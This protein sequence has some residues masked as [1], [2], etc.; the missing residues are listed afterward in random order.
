MSI[1]NDTATL[2]VDINS[3]QA[4]RRLAELKG[5]ADELR[6]SISD[7]MASGKADKVKIDIK[8]FKDVQREIKQ[9]QA[10]TVTAQE[11]M[12]RLDKAAPME[13]R[14]TLKTLR[15]ELEFCERGTEAWAKKSEEIRKVKEEIASV[16]KEL[17]AQQKV[18]E[19]ATNWIG[20]LYS[21]ATAAF[22]GAMKAVSGME[23]MIQAYADMDTA[24]ADTQKFTG[25]TAEDVKRLN[26]EFKKMDTRTSREELNALAS[27]AGRL[28]KQTVEDVLGF[29]RAGDQIKVAM[30]ELGDDAPQIISQLAGVF[31]LESEMGTE[32]AMLSVGSAINTLSQNCAASAPNLV[33]F[34]SR[35]GAMAAATGMTMDEMLSFGSIL[36][37]NRVSVEKS[38]TAMQ[39]V[40]NKMLADPSKFAEKAGMDVEKFNEALKRSS[41]EGLMMFIERLSGMDK[42]GVAETLANLNVAGSGVTTTFVTLANKVDDVKAQ[43]VAAKAAFSEAA[44]VGQEAAIQNET[45][46]ARL[47]KSK[48][49]LH[50]VAVA[51]GE[52]LAPM[53]LTAFDGLKSLSK[54]LVTV[55]DFAGE[56][57]RVIGSLATGVAAY[58]VVVQAAAV[59]T[60]VV[61]AATTAWKV[62]VAAC[63]AVVGLMTGGL[64]AMKLATESVN[65]A[66]KKN[67]IGL[68]AAL[69]ASAAAALW[70]WID[71]LRDEREAAEEARKAEEEWS[72][73]LTDVST[74]AADAAA[75]EISQLKMLYAA[76][77]DEAKS[78]EERLTAARRL[79]E[80]YPAVFGNMSKEEIMLGRARE[81]YEE[82]TESILLMA[83]A[84]AAAEKIKENEGQLMK[85]RDDQ[86][87]LKKWVNNRERLRDNAA[88]D[89]DRANKSTSL[90]GAVVRAVTPNNVDDKLEKAEGNLRFAKLVLDNKNKE[91]E[92]LETANRELT[93]EYAATL[94]SPTTPKGGGSVAAADDGED[95][96]ESG[97]GRTKS[98]KKG[99]GGKGG[100]K[101]NDK[102]AKENSWAEQEHLANLTAY[103]AGEKDY[104][105]I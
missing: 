50:E 82:L 4:A 73:S 38:A 39:A 29:V 77:T 55:I 7:A 8:A 5:R 31:N 41:T 74:A 47:D 88:S 53:A 23:S 54:A 43:F 49:A 80:L 3:E 33:D 15:R 10:D 104:E 68:V 95:V 59:K 6:K 17:S 9:I 62:A 28:G 98:K 40:M 24:M 61:T 89:V 56:H 44:S 19:K 83:K 26:E 18:T 100:G 97:G 93:E 36:D 27:M 67:V 22:A 60:K 63:H 52:K 1:N 81:K 65:A 16:N 37:A 42:N 11:V 94:T 87:T 76:A 84:Q 86:K 69:V 72:R 90:V 21:A 32:K 13:L 101:T 57:L 58:T 2:T 25:M 51:L 99:K 105:E 96:A 85:L 30:D 34:S 64:K 102:F 79:Q 103:R 66:M 46:Q 91:I 14:Q 92:K 71:K 48:Q 20:N 75:G 78:R 70:N 12:K 45:V 35:L